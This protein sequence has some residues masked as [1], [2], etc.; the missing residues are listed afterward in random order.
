[1]RALKTGMSKSND[2]NLNLQGNAKNRK[3]PI[4]PI[5]SLMHNEKRDENVFTN[6]PQHTQILITFFNN[7]TEWDAFKL[8]QQ[9]RFIRASSTNWNTYRA[10]NN[11]FFGIYIVRAISPVTNW[12]AKILYKSVTI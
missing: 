4:F 8:F 9:R 12:S 3:I 1:M 7:I 2:G 5:E 6:S 10:E 11:D